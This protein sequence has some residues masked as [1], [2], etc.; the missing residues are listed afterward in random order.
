MNPKKEG[1]S[2]LNSKGLDQASGAIVEE[3]N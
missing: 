2:R 3:K 1:E